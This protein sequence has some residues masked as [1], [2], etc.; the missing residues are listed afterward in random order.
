[1][2]ID[3]KLTEKE[4]DYFFLKLFEKSDTLDYYFVSDITEIFTKEKFTIDNKSNFYF[5]I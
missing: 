2:E 3:K 5:C 1:M 4:L